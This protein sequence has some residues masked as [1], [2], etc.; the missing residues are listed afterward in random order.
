MPMF[1]ISTFALMLILGLKLLELFGVFHF[2]WEKK[3]S[4]AYILIGMPAKIHYRGF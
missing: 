2:T 1:L 4:Y 3:Y